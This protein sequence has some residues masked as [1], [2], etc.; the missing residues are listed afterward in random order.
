[1]SYEDGSNYVA[2]RDSVFQETIDNL[3]E[4][5]QRR[6]ENLENL[7]ITESEPRSIMVVKTL[8]D[9]LHAVGLGGNYAGSSVRRKR[10]LLRAMK[11]TSSTTRRP[12][13]G[14]SESSVGSHGSSAI[15]LAY[16]SVSIRE[17]PMVPG[18]NPA[19]SRGVPLSIDWE[20]QW[21]GSFLLDTYEAKKTPRSQLEMRVPAEV[22][23]QL[24]R[25][26]GHSWK[27]IQSSTKIANI[28]RRQ[29]IKTIERLPTEKFDENIE[30]FVKGFKNMF[31]GKKKDEKDKESSKS[32]GGTRSKNEIDVS[33]SKSARG[34][35]LSIEPDEKDE[36]VI[37][38]DDSH[39]NS[40]KVYEF[41]IPSKG[42]VSYDA[43]NTSKVLDKPVPT[44]VVLPDDLTESDSIDH[45]YISLPSTVSEDYPSRRGAFPCCP[46]PAHSRSGVW[47]NIQSSTE[48]SHLPDYDSSGGILRRHYNARK[49]TP[50][51]HNKD[52]DKNIRRVTFWDGKEDPYSDPGS[53]FDLCCGGVFQSAGKLLRTPHFDPRALSGI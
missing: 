47:H 35:D 52:Q 4:E 16:N 1:M 8:D 18:D 34:Y 10:R 13:S 26:N 37:D 36:N 30:S 40:G 33:W 25:Q 38:I 21:E 23:S 6:K 41:G 28:T 19:V 20:H 11:F 31:K 27:D 9:S 45:S 24:L 14:N 44:M 53:D 12:R 50:L 43:S 17:Y 49:L 46:D 39:S 29:R 15:A 5:T 3:H 48:G 22:R 7:K 51:K 32:R 2:T 42:N